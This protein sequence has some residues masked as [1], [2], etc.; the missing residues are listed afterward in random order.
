[1]FVFVVVVGVCVGVWLTLVC[2]CVLFL[3]LVGWSSTWQNQHKSPAPV[4]RGGFLYHTMETQAEVRARVCACVSC[5]CSIGLNPSM[6]CVWGCGCAQ[7]D[8]HELW[9]AKRKNEIARK[10]NAAAVKAALDEWQQHRNRIE[11][12]I[13]RKIEAK[14]APPPYVVRGGTDAI[15]F[16]LLV[17]RVALHACMLCDVFGGASTN[18]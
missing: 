2:V 9:V 15:S 4:D 1:V 5:C 13:Q 14:R 11:A 6:L 16:P 10:K 8:M 17:E 18:P 3:G 7:F 12:E